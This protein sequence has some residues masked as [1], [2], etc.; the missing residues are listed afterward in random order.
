LTQS[1]ANA[2]KN[3]ALLPQEFLQKF[4]APKE[5]LIFTS[6]ALRAINSDRRPGNVLELQ[7]G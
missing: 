7:N 5:N 2:E 3:T 6:E 1:S 4:G